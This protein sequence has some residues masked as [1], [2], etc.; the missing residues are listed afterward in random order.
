MKSTRSESEDPYCVSMRFEIFPGRSRS[1]TGVLS[2]GRHP[3]LR[4]P[5][6]VLPSEVSY[7]ADGWLAYGDAE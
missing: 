7:S 4:R 3:A 6:D 5:L 2:G 1:S